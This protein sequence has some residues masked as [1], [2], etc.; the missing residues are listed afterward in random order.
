M[1]KIDLNQTANLHILTEED[2]VNLEFLYNEIK[3]EIEKI[4][5]RDSLPNATWFPSEDFKFLIRQQ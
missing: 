3:L 5:K 4:I 1:N 2:S